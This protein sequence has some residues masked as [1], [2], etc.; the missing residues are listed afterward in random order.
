VPP[1]IEAKWGSEVVDPSGRNLPSLKVRY[2][3]EHMPDAG[4]VLEVGSGEGKLLRTIAAHKPGLQLHGCDVR[5]PKSAPDVYKFLHMGA[6]IPAD[7][8]SFDVVLTFDVLEHVPDPAATLAEVSRVLKPNGK[9]VAFIPIEGE[10]ISAYELFRVLLGRDTYAETKEHIQ[11]FTHKG[12]DDLLARHF[13]VTDKRYAYH[14]LGQFM[15]A[16]FFAA[17]RLSAL[18]RF[19]WKDNVYY[20]GKT[21][22]DAS[23]GTSALNRLLE[24]GNLV[25][26]AESSLLSSNPIAAAGV[27]LEARLTKI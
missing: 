3:V 6:K 27:L 9:L 19:W 23:A 1:D 15:D 16:A 21:A 14:F 4:S 2:L 7:D 26:W 18:R 12:L 11:S 17:T 25:A 10:V 13:E 8:A 20:N 5:I 22:T 24:L